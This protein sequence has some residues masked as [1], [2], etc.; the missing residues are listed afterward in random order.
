M[1]TPRL[2]AATIPSGLSVGLL[3]QAQQ[4]RLLLPGSPFPSIP[5]ELRRVR[6]WPLTASTSRASPTLFLIHRSVAEKASNVEERPLRVSSNPT[7]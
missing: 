3:D 2:D 6:M 1:L 5:Q 4:Q 7:F